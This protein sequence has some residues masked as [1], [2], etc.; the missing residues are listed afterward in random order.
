MTEIESKKDGGGKV[1]SIHDVSAPNPPEVLREG[2][3]EEYSLSRFQ[4][5]IIKS[6]YGRKRYI[7]VEPQLDEKEEKIITRIKEIIEYKDE[8]IPLDVLKDDKLK[9][10][11]IEEETERLLEKLRVP[12]DKWDKIKY[13]ISRDLAGYGK[14]DAPMHDDF[15]EDLSCSG[16]GVPVYVWHIRHGYIP[17]N[18][19]FNSEEELESLVYKLSVLARKMISVANPSIEGILPDG[20]R[21]VCNLGMVSLKGPSFTIRKYTR[22][23]LSV[24]DLI[25]MNTISPRLAAYFWILIENKKSLVVIGEVGA[26]KTTLSNALLGFIRKSSKVIT[27]EET[28]E[29]RLEGYENWSQKITRES[30]RE[31]VRSIDLFELVKTALRER[32]DY[33]IVGEVRGRESYVLFQSIALG[34]GGLTTLHADDVESAIKRLTSKPLDIPLYLVS[35]AS[36]FVKVAK[37]VTERGEVKRRV[38]TVKEVEALKEEEIEF[39]EVFRYIPE[40]DSIEM[41]GESIVFKKIA[42]ERGISLDELYEEFNFREQFLAYLSGLEGIDWKRFSDIIERYYIEG[43][44]LLEVLRSEGG[45]L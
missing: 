42:A 14:I 37:I 16:V 20:S 8:S 29:I 27:I 1:E 36:A 10:K 33:V 2:V 41:V 19:V 4:K 38:M 26:G 12:E 28:P 7:V 39:R 31:D 17:T 15:I 34:H 21:V 25:K 13:Y 18:I 9:K 6:E 24:A 45:A 44:R 32:P 3:L 22:I 23:P 40:S 5:I 30:V 43:K 11:Y 35:L